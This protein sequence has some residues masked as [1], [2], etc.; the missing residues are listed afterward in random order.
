MMRLLLPVQLLKKK[1]KGEL[2][3]NLMYTLSIQP[4]LF[5]HTHLGHIRQ[6]W[7]LPFVPSSLFA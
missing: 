1:K 6:L 7:E 4:I 2:A 3:D 5:N